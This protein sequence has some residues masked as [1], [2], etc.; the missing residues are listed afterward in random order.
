M[1]GQRTKTWN[2]TRK[3]ST[4]LIGA[5]VLRDGMTCAYCG[6]E[7]WG[8]DFQIDHV[9]PLHLGGLNKHWNMVISCDTCNQRKGNGPVPLDAREEVR[10]RVRRPIDLEAG[11]RMGDRLYPWAPAKRAYM[12]AYQAKKREE[13]RGYPL[14]TSFP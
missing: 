6:C 3:L 11:Q 10:R 5:L 8:T 12:R 9:K 13:K 1:G 7:L 4:A 2:R 14:D